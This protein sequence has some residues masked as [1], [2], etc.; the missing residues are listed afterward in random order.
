MKT[1]RSMSSTGD[2]PE[3]WRLEELEPYYETY[4]GAAYLGDAV[5]LIKLIDDKSV[6]LIITSPPFALNRKKEYGNVEPE[7]YVSWFSPFAEEFRRVLAPRGSLVIHLG[8]SWSEGEPV[9]TLYTYEL[10]LSLCKEYG[11]KLAQDFYW[12][13]P[14]KLPSPAEWVTV[15]RVRVKD[16]VDF[17]WWLSQSSNPRAD[18]KRVLKPYSESMLELFEKGYKPLL[19]PSGHDIS[20]KFGKRNGGAIPPNIIIAANTSSNDRYLRLCREHGVK[21]NPARY[22]EKIP[23]FFIKFLTNE[24]DKVLD[25]FG[26]SNTT[27][28]VAEKLGRRWMC[29]ELREEYLRGSMFRFQAHQIL[30]SKVEYPI[31]D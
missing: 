23:E 17:I 20:S 18:N 12:Y 26:G 28:Y 30:K 2:R 19:R 5:E 7:R 29:F 25:P 14:A 13:N 6:D 24:G 1:A 21:P 3:P 10:L 8:G 15:R 11:F 9:K 16:A 22:P 31:R 4:Y 27:G